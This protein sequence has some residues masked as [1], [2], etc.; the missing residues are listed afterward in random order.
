MVVT[1][2]LKMPRPIK[3]AVAT[4]ITMAVN[5]PVFAF[6]AEPTNV[7]RFGRLVFV[8]LIGSFGEWVVTAMG[9]EYKRG[10]RRTRG[11]LP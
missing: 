9:I 6:V 1:M 4:A 11:V 2:V 8:S 3:A 5:T 7:S 10:V